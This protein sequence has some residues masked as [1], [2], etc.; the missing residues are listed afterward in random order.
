[1]NSLRPVVT[2]GFL[3]IVGLFLWM[4]INETEPVVPEDAVGWNLDAEL[5]IGDPEFPSESSFEASTASGEED[6]SAPSF[7]SP[8]PFATA[9]AYNAQT[10][11]EAP[12]AFQ[13]PA[14]SAPAMGVATAAPKTTPKLTAPPAFNTP[15]T[16]AA[17]L[18]SQPLGETPDLPPLPAIPRSAAVAATTAA[19]TAAAVKLAQEATPPANSLR[20]SPSASNSTPLASQPAPSKAATASPFDTQ[21][22]ASATESF[23]P[24]A[25]STNQTSLYSAT[26]LAVQGAL[27]RG[28]LAQ[29]LLM[30]S[31]WYGDP[32]LTTAEATE[33]QE[34]LG[35][36]AG[37][38]IYS[39]EHRLEPP[40][41]VKPGESLEDIAGQYNVPW[42]LLAKINGLSNPDAVQPG[43]QLKVVRGPFS[44]RIDL[45]KRKLVM[46]LDR[47]YAGQFDIDID[48]LS[49]IEEGYWSVNQKLLT[50]A[51]A[52][53]PSQAGISTGEERSILLTSTTTGVSQ[54]T[55]LRGISPTPSGNDLAG[56]VIQLQARDVD[57]VYNILTLGSQVIIRR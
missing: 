21:N 33:V 2:I 22:P 37:S 36:L 29:A 1:M 44:A 10:M 52:G 47:R 45:G 25:A 6:S 42:Q 13:P 19:T 4:K 15:S 26:R 38:V 43:Q 23:P 35:Q 54:V 7:G 46:M 31:D 30:L 9:P 55:V 50:P 24:A 32:S 53:T 18:T 8:Q 16:Q 11:S 51:N 3:G 14:N 17:P 48:P 41:L 49:S 12:P 57:D 40:Y 5:E 27:D 28:E 56:R 34:L 39:T 20:T